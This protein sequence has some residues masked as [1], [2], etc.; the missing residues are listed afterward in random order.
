MN[1]RTKLLLVAGLLGGL[2]VAVLSNFHVR[3][4]VQLVAMK[5]L[6]R[7]SYMSWH[8]V[9]EILHG[10]RNGEVPAAVAEAR[11]RNGRE[12][13]SHQ[14]S[15]CH[16]ADARGGSAPDLTQG[17]FRHGG[18]DADLLRTITEGVAGTPMGPRDMP[19]ESIRQII[20]FLRATGATNASGQG[21]L[22]TGDPRRLAA[23]SPFQV[24]FARLVSAASDSGEWLMYS[25]S[26]SAQRH[27]RLAQITP[28]NAAALRL[29]W[30]FQLP[31]NISNAAE[32]TPLVVGD[33][34]FVTLPPNSVWALDARTGKELWAWNGPQPEA[35]RAS[36]IANRGVAI[37]GNALFVGTMD[38]HLVSLNAQTGKLLWDVKV[39][40]SKDGY[41][42]TSAPLALHDKVIVGVAGGEL[43]IRGFIDAYSATTGKLLW[44]FYTV[45]A[46]G[47]PGHETWGGGDAWRKGGAPTWVTGSYDA[48]LGLIYW[49][50]GNPAP[51]FQGDVRPGANLYS[52]SVVALDAETGK[53]R[54]HFQFTPHDEHDWDA[55]QIPI[56]ADAVFNG[57]PRKL[58]YWPNRNAFYYVLDRETGQFLHAREFTQQTWATGIDSA[59]KPIEIPGHR[60]TTEGTLTSP[61]VH[62]ATN[63]W[64]PSY[65]PAS[66]TVFVPTMESV[67]N[68]TKGAAVSDRNGGFDGSAGVDDL[69]QPIWTTVRALDASTGAIRWQYHFPPHGTAPLMGGVLSTDGGLVFAGD[70]TRFVGLDARTGLELW[71]FNAGGQIA[72][73]PITY[74]SEGRQ[75]VTVAA[76]GV[77]ETF[78]LEG[79]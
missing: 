78:S 3:W 30:L 76:G 70:E 49:G 54:W 21:R 50:V 62:G 11:V 34:M 44:R 13:F 22:P 4:R 43:G 73:A 59:G 19:I 12:I 28:A 10:G 61:S 71:Q 27:S 31:L 18:S 69:S 6:G 36:N 2:S 25:G 26:Y 51:D 75:Q 74:L 15:Q 40:E 7:V 77:I 9:A 53:L 56:L 45:P 38:A 41:A 42:M 33:A 16:G 55:A 24:D 14:C 35:V 32:T 65:D 5:A 48:A 20:A 17:Q 37:Y 58:M 1:R 29:K 60:P 46:P 47:E 23:A 52:C 79:R 64:S 72:A 39:A 8:D 57:K 66:G 68:F 67:G 63:W